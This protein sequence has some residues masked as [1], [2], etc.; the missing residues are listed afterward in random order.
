M[1][2]FLTDYHLADVDTEPL[3]VITNK[4]AVQFICQSI[5]SV[6][7]YAFL[8]RHQ[9]TTSVPLKLRGHIFKLL[10]SVMQQS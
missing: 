2:K 1:E 7:K 3:M 8:Q 6:M 4:S 9:N 10:L 5:I